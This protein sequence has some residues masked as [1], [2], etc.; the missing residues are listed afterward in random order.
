MEDLQKSL[1]ESEADHRE[2][3]ENI[4][5]KSDAE[6]L[7]MHRKMEKFYMSYEEKIEKLNEQHEQQMSR[8]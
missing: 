5:T 8:F 3:L 4:Q 2:A 7:E 6:L 1:N